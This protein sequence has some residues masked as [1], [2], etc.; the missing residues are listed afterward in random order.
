M[1]KRSLALA[2]LATG[3]LLTASAVAD[4]QSPKPFHGVTVLGSNI[5]IRSSSS[6]LST[7]YKGT[8]GPYAED[9]VVLISSRG[10]LDFGNALGKD[11]MHFVL[12]VGGKTETDRWAIA[13]SFLTGPRITYSLGED[14]TVFIPK[15]E[16]KTL[17][18]SAEN[19]GDFDPKTAITTATA[20][21]TVLAAKG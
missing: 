15:G 2:L 9:A 16:V 11:N 5:E 17:T 3:S 8:I 1:L 20:H 6:G 21:L 18:M 13:S 10:E 14:K 7:A 12:E 4:D 19:T